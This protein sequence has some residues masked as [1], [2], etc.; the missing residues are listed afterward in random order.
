MDFLDRSAGAENA[1][2]EMAERIARASLSSEVR[3]EIADAGPAELRR[4][5]PPTPDRIETVTVR[6]A[7]EVLAPGTARASG[8]LVLLE[9]VNGVTLYLNTGGKVV[10]LHTPTPGNIKFTSFNSAVVKQI[11]CGPVLN[12]GVPAQI[13]YRVRPA[14]ESIGEPL[15]VE[16]IDTG[17]VNIGASMSMP[18]STIVGLLTTLDCS[19]GVAFTVVSEGKTL[20]FRTDSA[21]KVAFLNGPNPDGTVDCGPIAPPGLA[22]SVFY[23][24]STAAGL[25]GEPVI[26][27]FQR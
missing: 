3:P 27:R 8:M 5:Q 21:S 10:K 17:S 22:V 4:S 23:R 9:C 2:R 7:A 14:G 19:S 26:V 25:D 11:S 16:F 24:P 13:V 12:N 18:G 1:N 6:R 20:R 15:T